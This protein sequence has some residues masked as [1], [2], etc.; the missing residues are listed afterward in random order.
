[1]WLRLDA[2]TGIRHGSPV[3]ARLFLRINFEPAGTWLGPGMI[4]LLERVAAHGSI[5]AAA[6]SMN[7]SYRK[8]WLL[9]Q[10]MQDTFNG[11]VVTTAIGGSAGGGSRLTELGE[12]LLKTYRR[13]ESCA[14]DVVEAELKALDGMVKTDG[15]PRRAAKPGSKSTTAK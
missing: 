13:V 4:Q 1:M 15:A 8:A 6:A 10:K 11:Q 5:R 9:I 14:A 12:T 3:M 7:M 2:R